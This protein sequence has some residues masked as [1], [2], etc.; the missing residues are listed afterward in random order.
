MAA[1]GSSIECGLL[2]GS[3]RYEDLELVVE[4]DPE[5]GSGFGALMLAFLDSR[6]DVDLDGDGAAD[7][8]SA[9]FSFHAVPALIDRD[10]ACVD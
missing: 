6:L 5:I 4:N 7:A 1:D 9:A 2:A 8:L 10:G 3:V